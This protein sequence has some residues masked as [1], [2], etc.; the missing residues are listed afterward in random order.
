MNS[1]RNS[2]LNMNNKI[3]FL[4]NGVK[5]ILLVF[6]PLVLFVYVP[7]VF[8]QSSFV[9]LAPIPGLTDTNALSVA[10]STNLASFFNNLYKYAIGL[11]AVFAV[12][13]IIWGGLQISTQDSISKQGEGKERI[14][15]AIFGLVLVLSPVLVFTIINPNILNL[16]LNLPP[17]ELPVPAS[18]STT[19]TLPICAAS[20]TTNCTKPV[21]NSYRTTNCIPPTGGTGAT[22]GITNTGAQP[23]C[24]PNVSGSC[25]TSPPAC[26]SGQWCYSTVDS[27][28]IPSTECFTSQNGCT[29]LYN[30][31]IQGGYGVTVISGSSCTLCP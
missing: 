24:G 23:L 6:L 4:S 19:T 31:Q 22:S 10:N 21:C 30:A 9:P 20:Q 1:V 11:A 17:I 2:Q 16:S 26:T 25:V 8:A 3:K 12:I 7:H 15:Q 28:Q 27:N 5:K 29:T 14:Q 13:E 18:P